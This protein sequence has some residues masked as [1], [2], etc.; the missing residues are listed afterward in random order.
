MLTSREAWARPLLLAHFEQLGPQ[1]R[2]VAE[3]LG[4]HGGG[5]PR[6]VRLVLLEV[7]GGE[8]FLHDSDAWIRRLALLG[9]CT[10]ELPEAL[11]DEVKDV[12]AHDPDPQ[13]R[14]VAELVLAL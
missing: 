2:R 10:P 12:A 1:R 6:E 14:A 3:H 8:R 13:V 4:V 11:R 9:L 5:V 7:C